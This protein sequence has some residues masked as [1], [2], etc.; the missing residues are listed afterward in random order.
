MKLGEIG[1]RETGLLQMACLPT[2]VT[3]LDSEGRFLMALIFAFL[4]IKSLTFTT[5]GPYLH[6]SSNFMV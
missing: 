5:F 4:A 1:V 3:N 6:I 2:V